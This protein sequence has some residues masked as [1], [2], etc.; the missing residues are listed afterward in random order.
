[1][2]SGP[3]CSIF[4][5]KQIHLARDVQNVLL[6]RSMVRC[7]AD[8]NVMVSRSSRMIVVERLPLLHV[9]N[10]DAS[11]TM[12]YYHTIICRDLPLIRCL[13][14]HGAKVDDYKELFCGTQ[15][16]GILFPRVVIRV[17][18]RNGLREAS[19]MKRL[20]CSNSLRSLC[21]VFG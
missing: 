21:N 15:Y 6:I 9:A 19:L 4:R 20:I 8:P 13:R 18:I 1:M 14:K 12:S 17:L 11:T 2:L 16:R 7:R 3:F 10:F 5:F